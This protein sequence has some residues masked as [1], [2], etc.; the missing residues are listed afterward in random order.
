[1]Y[2]LGREDVCIRQFISRS[3]LEG[4]PVS[5]F[6]W[7]CQPE[8]CADD[9]IVMQSEQ[10]EVFKTKMVL[11]LAFVRSTSGLSAL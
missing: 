2:V 1:M 4:K 11:S 9:Q 8:Q 5:I 10:F 6:C 3:L 7:M